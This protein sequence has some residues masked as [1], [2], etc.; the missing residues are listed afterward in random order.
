[1]YI[2]VCIVKDQK[3]QLVRVDMNTLPLSFYDN[4]PWH[5]EDVQDA[6]LKHVCSTEMIGMPCKKLVW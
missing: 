3:I 5:Y 6:T 2:H 1:M 4:D